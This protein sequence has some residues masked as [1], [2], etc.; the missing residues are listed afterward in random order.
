MADKGVEGKKTTSTTVDVCIACT[1]MADVVGK[2]KTMP[3]PR[4]M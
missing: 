2:Q 1:I 3:A 4:K